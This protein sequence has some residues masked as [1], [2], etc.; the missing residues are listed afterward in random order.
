MPL[1]N[2]FKNRAILFHLSWK[3]CVFYPKGP[4]IVTGWMTAKCW[5]RFR[6]VVHFSCQA[7]KQYFQLTATA[8]GDNAV[9]F[10]ITFPNSLSSSDN[11]PGFSVYSFTLTAGR[12]CVVEKSPWVSH[13][14]ATLTD[15][16]LLHKKQ[17]SLISYRK[18]VRLF[19]ISQ[20][21]Q[22]LCVKT[23]RFLAIK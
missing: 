4:P 20:N 21:L 2:L 11:M 23:E 16:G 6:P 3:R 22:L 1:G 15:S 18:M 10:K 14:K 5:V 17:L 13:L 9:G 7:T 19:M 12:G 8:F